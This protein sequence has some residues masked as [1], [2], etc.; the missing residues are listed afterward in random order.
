MQN[1]LNFARAV[2]KFAIPESSPVP[3]CGLQSGGLDATAF[4][5]KIIEKWWIL[6]GNG[7][8]SLG[9]ASGRQNGTGL[10]LEIAQMC[11]KLAKEIVI[12]PGSA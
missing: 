1:R 3:F 12:R 6:L 9:S 5:L 7:H 2:R 10:G 4:C 11:F 8:I